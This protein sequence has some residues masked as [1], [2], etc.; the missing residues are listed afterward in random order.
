MAGLRGRPYLWLREAYTNNPSYLPEADSLVLGMSCALW[1][2]YGLTENLL[3]SRLMPRILALA[4]QMW[5]QG[6]SCHGRISKNESRRCDHGSK[7]K[8]IATVAT[9]HTLH[10][11]TNKT[12]LTQ[13]T[14]YLLMKKK[15]ILAAAV[16]GFLPSLAM[17]QNTVPPS[18]KHHPHDQRR[19]FAQ[20]RFPRPLMQFYRNPANQKLNLDPYLCGT[21]RTSSSN[22]PIG[23]S[24][25]TTSCYMSGQPSISGFVSTYPYSCGEADLFSIDTA[26]AYQPTLTLLEAARINRN[27]ATGLVITCEFPHATPADCSAHSYNRGKYE[28]MCRRWSATGSTSS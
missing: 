11:K 17:G 21:V 5:H 23:D 25:P 16:L 28:W 13:E 14:N 15:L 9:K 27:A 6:P 4:E 24:A 26:R 1:T 18:E 22:A 12:L 2:D 19:H 3:D 10:H 7:H 8:V 20:Q